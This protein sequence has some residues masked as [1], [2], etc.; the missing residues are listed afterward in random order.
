MVAT[1]PTISRDKI[2]ASREALLAVKRNDSINA[3][4]DKITALT[5]DCSW[6]DFARA[7]CEL[8][9]PDHK[10]PEEEQDVIRAAGSM[11][12]WSEALAGIVNVQVLAGYAN[13]RDPY[14]GIVNRAAL[15]NFQKQRLLAIDEPVSLER[16]SRGGTAKVKH[17]G[18]SVEHIRLLRMAAQVRLDEQDLLDNEGVDVLNQYAREL[19]RVAK[20]TVLDLV[21]ATILENPALQTDSTAVFDSASHGNLGSAAMG[22]PGLQNAC[23]AMLNQTGTAANGELVHFGIM[24]RYLVTPPA[25][26]TDG[27]ELAR[28]LKLNDGADLTVRCDSRL[29]A[30]GCTDPR[31]GSTRTGSDSA[32]Y[33]FG[34][35]ADGPSLVLAGL[36][37]NTSPKVSSFQL[38]QGEWGAGLALALDIGCGWSGYR[39]A[40][41]STGE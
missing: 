37:G 29:G 2:D 12:T 3:K 23:A 9:R 24:P 31:T 22:S 36:N 19:G 35:A 13:I 14:A 32:W 17:M 41:K 33:L 7:F 40:Y 11:H 25:L 1:L 20:R 16:L 5:K 18:G 34:A 38:S 6:S 39:L 26:F 4:A 27:R 8:Y 21:A 10:V 28:A 30:T 15:N